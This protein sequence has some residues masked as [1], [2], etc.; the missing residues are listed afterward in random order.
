MHVCSCF[1]CLLVFL[2]LRCELEVIASAPKMLE[3]LGDKRLHKDWCW[4]SVAD[5]GVDGLSWLDDPAGGQGPPLRWG[6]D[7]MGGEV[8]PGLTA[9]ISAAYIPKCL[10]LGFFS[11]AAPPKVDS[12]SPTGD[13]KLDSLEVG[14][15]VAQ[16]LSCALSAAGLLCTHLT[17]LRVYAVNPGHEVDS[18]LQQCISHLTSQE[19]LYGSEPAATV[20]PC[21]ALWPG[22]VLAVQLMAMDLP[23]MQTQM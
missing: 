13:M 8:L 19:E 4:N 2:L 1:D 7:K 10:C 23:Q 6:L 20:V 17:H 3:L 21:A 15:V 9:S 18:I 16:A 14:V 5:H 11:L 22:C 12:D